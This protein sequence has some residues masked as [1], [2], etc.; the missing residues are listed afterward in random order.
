[1]F[2]NFHRDLG[3]NNLSGSIPSEIGNLTN[4]EWL[5]L[6]NNNLSGPIPPELGGL[7][8][9]NT[10]DLSLNNISGT[11]P[12]LNVSGTCNAMEN[13]LLCVPSYYSQKCQIM[14]SCP[15][16]TGSSAQKS[17]I[18]VIA[19]SVTAFFCLLICLGVI[20]LVRI[21]KDK[22]SKVKQIPLSEIKLSEIK[23]PE[24]KLPETEQSEIDTIPMIPTGDIF[25][26]RKLGEGKFS[27]VF[28][29][30]WKGTII[31]MK[32][33]KKN[34]PRISMMKQTDYGKL[35]TLILFYC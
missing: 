5:Y 35:I 28:Q 33:L 16:S 21:I 25:I 22:K 26:G 7:K 19:G 27:E 1:M 24:I 14:N 23:L 10:L 9:L 6:D 17:Y 18:G 2:L 12:V 34:M 4:L 11:L 32:R 30:D 3:S 8:K 13:P 15:Q 31:A 20:A 29:G